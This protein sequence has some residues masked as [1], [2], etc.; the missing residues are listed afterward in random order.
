VEIPLEDLTAYQLLEKYKKLQETQS[1]DI[2][3]LNQ[4]HAEEVAHLNAKIQ[5]LEKENATFKKTEFVEH[6]GA[7]FKRLPNGGYHEAVYCPK[8]K[9]SASL[10]HDS[11]PYSCYCGWAS[12]FSPNEL[13]MIRATLHQ[14][15]PVS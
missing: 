9:I 2:L 12:N 3:K 7:L 11:M 15:S 4:K 10:I 13:L 6:H 5:Q 1:G 8:C 14:A